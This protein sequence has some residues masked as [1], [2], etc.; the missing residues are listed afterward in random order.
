MA[1]DVHKLKANVQKAVE[2]GKHKKAAEIYLELASAEPNEG[3]WPHRAGEMYKKVG[4]KP[5][6]VKA[7]REAADRYSRRGFLLKAI[8]VCKLI[9]D[10]DPQQTEAQE[11]LA[12]LY[13]DPQA[14]PVRPVR[15]TPTIPPGKGLEAAPP[16]ETLMPDAKTGPTEGMFEIPLEEAVP[17]EEPV[18]EAQDVDLEEVVELVAED[19]RP[20]LQ[21]LPSTPLFSSLDEQTLRHLIERVQMLQAPA[22]FP[23]T[24]G[25]EEANS[26]YVIVSGRVAIRHEGREGEEQVGEGDFFG[27]VALLEGVP[28]PAMAVALEDSD[29]LEIPC[30]VVGEVIDRQPDFM[31]VILRLLRER[32]LSHL[33][34]SSPLFSDYS[35]EERESIATRF[36]FV[37]V[38]PDTLLIREGER[39]MGLCLMMAGHAEVFSDGDG[40]LGTL[41]PGDLF[42]EMSLLTKGP[43]VASIRSLTKCW[44]LLLQREDFDEMVLTNPRALEFVTALA[45][46]RRRINAA[47]AAGQ[48]TID[49]ARLPLS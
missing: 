47:I 5:G 33:L 23:V 45:D 9:L 7:L 1:A 20:P 17:V 42:G 28:R 3:L 11:L 14:G 24:T 19:G 46:E 16:L 6:A 18:V 32:L 12:R 34:R 26:L 29:L 8:A 31:R 49:D 30:S 39:T 40:M 37:E 36:R 48:L 27:E 22:G 25:G 21:N 35:D 15:R 2:G 10:V 44:V 4:E 43:A 41:G 38:R 13:A